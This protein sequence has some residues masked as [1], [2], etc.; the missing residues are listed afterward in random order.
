MARYATEAR[1]RIWSTP[2][3]CTRQHRVGILDSLLSKDIRERQL[4]ILIQHRLINGRIKRFT[5]VKQHVK[6]MTEG[7][8]RY[9]VIDLETGKMPSNSLVKQVGQHLVIEIDD[10]D[11]VIELTN[12]Y[13]VCSS[14]MSCFLEVNPM[15]VISGQPEVA[16]IVFT[17][18]NARDANT[19]QVE[20][21]LYSS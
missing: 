13:S 17:S 20:S 9:E 1:K 18:A 7:N 4:T 11:T 10:R 21:V 15:P 19:D 2:P 3:S 6:I 14:D 8:V 16:T 12:F 5:F